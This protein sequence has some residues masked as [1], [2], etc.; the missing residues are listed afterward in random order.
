MIQNWN[1][2]TNVIDRMPPLIT[3]SRT[4]TPVVAT[5][6]Q[7]GSAV[8][9]VSAKPAPC[10]CGS[11][12]SQQMSSTTAVLSRRST[13]E[14]SRASAKSG[15][16]YAPERRSGAATN[17]CSARYPTTNATGY[18]SASAP[19]AMISPA[20]PR[21]EAADRYSPEIALAFVNGFTVREAT[22]KSDVLRVKRTPRKPMAAEASATIPMAV[23]VTM[24]D[25]LTAAAP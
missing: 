25:G 3:V 8:S 20:I 19:T 14:P 1:A 5:P 16:V 13:G 4:T 7:D 2:C 6:V 17:S 21:N 12:Y 11:M 18:Q 9:A 10:S 15:T 22:R 23:S 24:P